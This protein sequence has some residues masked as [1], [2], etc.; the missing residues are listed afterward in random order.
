[1]LEKLIVRLTKEFEE[2]STKK[3]IIL[4]GL[5]VLAMG[6]WVNLLFFSQGTEE[7]FENKGQDKIELN[8]QLYD[9]QSSQEEIDLYQLYGIEE[10]VR[11]SPFL[12]LAELSKSKFSYQNERK[13]KEGFQDDSGTKL[14]DGSEFNFEV[15]I[16]GVVNRAEESL[17]LL[18]L[19]GESKLAQVD[20]QISGFKIEAILD[21]QIII[22]RDT[23]R[24]SFGF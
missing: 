7:A 18:E 16:L 24:Y 21:N 2:T 4:L 14:K 9:E 20:D 23:G 11:E 22:E 3:L 19:N 15:E 6:L 8:E 10:V 5:T 12:N 17:V 1:M 13:I